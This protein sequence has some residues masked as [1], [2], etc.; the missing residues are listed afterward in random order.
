M[1]EWRSGTPVVKSMSD[2]RRRMDVCLLAGREITEHRQ[3][4]E[5]YVLSGNSVTITCRY[6]KNMSVIERRARM[7]F[8]GRQRWSH[9]IDAADGTWPV[10]STLIWFK[11][12][13]KVEQAWPWQ[14]GSV[15]S[16]AQMKKYGEKD[17]EGLKWNMRIK[18]CFGCVV[19]VTYCFI[20]SNSESS[21]YML[22]ELLHWGAV[23]VGLV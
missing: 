4:P 18:F 3:K 13:F 6:L 2:E 23:S 15:K 1:L 14:S 21:V 11:K 20:V 19:F 8:R 22:L 17:P 10:C 16:L 9:W 12:G 7:A 5:S